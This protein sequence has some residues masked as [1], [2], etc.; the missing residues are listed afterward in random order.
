MNPMEMADW[1]IWDLDTTNSLR[2]A[3]R[4]ARQIRCLL[5]TLAIFLS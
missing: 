4:Q 2:Q 1:K 3:Q 5:T